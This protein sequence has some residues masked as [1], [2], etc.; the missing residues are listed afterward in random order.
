MQKKVDPPAGITALPND[1]EAIVIGPIK[2]RGG[3]I[4]RMP[5]RVLLISL[6][7]TVALFALGYLLVR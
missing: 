2:A 4:N 1:E 5:I 7:L 3:T 6:T